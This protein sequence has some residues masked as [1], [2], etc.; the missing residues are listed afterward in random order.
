MFFKKGIADGL[1]KEALITREN[2]AEELGYPL[3][4]VSAVLDGEAE[5]GEELTLLLL[6]AFGDEV[7]DDAIDWQRMK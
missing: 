6:S 7:M 1:L 3:K 4:H 2:L 5:A